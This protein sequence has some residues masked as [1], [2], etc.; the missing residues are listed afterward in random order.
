MKYTYVRTGGLILE[1]GVLASTYGIIP[2][3]VH[4]QMGCSVRILNPQSYSQSLWLVNST[5]QEH[6][7]SCVGAN[8]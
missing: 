1:G 4:F 2:F 3:H 7:R 6:F 5:L 8:V